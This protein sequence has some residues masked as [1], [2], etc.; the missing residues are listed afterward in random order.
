VQF[1]SSTLEATRGRLLARFGARVEP[2]WERLPAAIAELAE[3]WELV[4]GDA[5]GRGNT[6]LVVRCRRADGRRAV[7]K[8]TPDAE[9]GAAAASALRSWESSGRVPL[10]WGY[11]A[12]SGTL[13]LEAVPGEIPLSEL[14]MAVELDKVANLI[15]GLHRSGAP[16]VANGVVSLA[17]RV[18]FIFEH[19]VERHARRGEMVTR[20]VPVERLRRGHELARG[21]V[22]DAGAPVLLHG[23]LHPGNVLD[24]GA[25]RGLVAIDPRPCVG[26]AAVDA[27]DWVFWAVDDPRGWQPR[28][29]DLALALGVDH[30]RLWAWCAAFAAMLAASKAARGAA[31]EEV[32]ALLTLAP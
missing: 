22:A 29:R 2:W 31:A 17:E 25:A 4:V 26:E 3:R 15:G 1:S 27:V 8:L 10:V 5:V 6:S 14:G 18:E 28:S 30:E 20:A 24:G 32:A 7:L 23:D 19:W 9:L 16:V 12:A 11:D 21:L 13:L